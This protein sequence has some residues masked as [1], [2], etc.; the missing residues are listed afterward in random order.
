[1]ILCVY[2]AFIYLLTHIPNV[3]RYAPEAWRFQNVDKLVHFGMYAGW[4][5]LWW[6]LLSCGGRRVSPL[7]IRWILVGGAL[8]GAFDELTQGIVGRTPDLVDW[9]C[10]M[11][12]V[13][14]VTAV[15][16]AWQNRQRTTSVVL[17]QDTNTLD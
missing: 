6:W 5:V 4:T 10:N 1:M 3:D 8:Y 15:L 17:R 9:A 12:A 14:L 2:W 7:A 13:V 16:S 11:A